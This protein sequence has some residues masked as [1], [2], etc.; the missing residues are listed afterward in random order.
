MVIEWEWRREDAAA[1]AWDEAIDVYGAYA[2]GEIVRLLTQQRSD[3]DVDDPD[4][5]LAEQLGVANPFPVETAEDGTVWNHY[6]A[7]CEERDGINGFEF[8]ESFP[9]LEEGMKAINSER[10]A[11]IAMIRESQ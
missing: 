1:Y 2:L 5:A 4:D 11:L 10:D 8:I 9:T 6:R 7:H 3:S